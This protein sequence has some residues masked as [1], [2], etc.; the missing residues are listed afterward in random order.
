MVETSSALLLDSLISALLKS[1]FYHVDPTLDS[2]DTTQEVLEFAQHAREQTHQDC[3]ANK[4]TT[5]HGQAEN[6][7][8]PNVGP[9]M[10]HFL[11]RVCKMCQNKSCHYIDNTD[12]NQFLE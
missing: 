4:E 11:I 5:K 2:K 8:E 10:S 3:E 1:H 9:T 6:S 12:F 7:D